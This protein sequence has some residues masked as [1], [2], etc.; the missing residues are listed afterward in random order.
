VRWL[1]VGMGTEN[2]MHTPIFFNQVRPIIPLH[3]SIMLRARSR[4]T[5]CFSAP[6]LSCCFRQACCVAEVMLAG[7]LEH[8]VVVSCLSNVLCC[9]VTVMPESLG[10]DFDLLTSPSEP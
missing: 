4:Q 2:D 5:L 8:A 10:C 3:P 9:C 6:L 7:R 1:T